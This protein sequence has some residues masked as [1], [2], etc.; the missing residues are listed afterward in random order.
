MAD[1]V[2]VGWGAPKIGLKKAGETEIK[3]FAT[4]VEGT[5]TLEA[6]QGDKMEAKIEG[7]TNEAVKYK[8]NTYTFTFDVRQ[9]P[10][11]TDPVEGLDGVVEGEYMVIIYPENDSAIHAVLKRTVIN[12]QEKFDA[13]NGLVRT[14]TFDVLKPSDGSAQ[15]VLG[16]K[17]EVEAIAGVTTE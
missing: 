14:Y 6:S 8:A 17:T 4:P 11:R 16:S 13:E 9:V 15:V 12:I 1:T 3:F 10:E 7:G 2:T 5:T